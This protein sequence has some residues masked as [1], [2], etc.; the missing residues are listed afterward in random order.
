[1]FHM[2]VEMF[3]IFL[4]SLLCVTNQCLAQTQFA[5]RSTSADISYEYN[6]PESGFLIWSFDSV[7]ILT[8]SFAAQ[9]V[10]Y[11]ADESKYS[12]IL[13]DYSLRIS[14][15][16][17]HDEGLYQCRPIIGPPFQTNLIVYG[18]CFSMCIH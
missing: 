3:R 5:A 12:F 2:S 4:L 7:D 9:S 17:I 15:V 13:A 8:Y 1:M 18:E 14:S 6:G 16:E 11:N 10:S